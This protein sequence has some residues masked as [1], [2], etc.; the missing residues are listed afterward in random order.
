MTCSS[1]F[2][3]RRPVVPETCRRR[4]V[5]QAK[6]SRGGGR[7]RPT[8]AFAELCARANR[9]DEAKVN[10]K[11]AAADPAAIAA[12]TMVGIILQAQRSPKS[13]GAL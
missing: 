1:V 12:S 5:P 6:S 13:D 3:A 4:A 9:L 2:V 11:I 10:A 7:R 8:A